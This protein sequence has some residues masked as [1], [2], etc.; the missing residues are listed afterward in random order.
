[1]E[2]TNL[3]C[4]VSPLLRTS[5]SG[6]GSGAGLVCAAP[7]SVAP[8]TIAKSKT[9]ATVGALQTGVVEKKNRKVMEE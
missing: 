2:L 7:V 1:M 5:T 4:N 8:V 9:R 3:P 6:S